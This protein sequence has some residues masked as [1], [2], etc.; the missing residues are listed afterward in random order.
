M[1]NKKL[2]PGGVYYCPVTL[3]MI[4]FEHYFDGALGTKCVAFKT[5]ES[6]EYGY[7]STYLSKYVFNMLY[8]HLEDLGD[9]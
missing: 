6:G 1:A 9:L 2:K 3:R 7:R 5:Y 8:K 4:E